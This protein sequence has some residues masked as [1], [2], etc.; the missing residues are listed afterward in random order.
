MTM[1]EFGRR[2]NAGSRKSPSRV[3]A[4]R[5][6]STCG[7]TG[8]AGI[9]R[10][11]RSVL[12]GIGA[13]GLIALAAALIMTTAAAADVLVGKNGARWEGTVTEEDGR[14][15][16][17][18][19]SGGRMVF[20]KDTIAEV[21]VSDDLTEEYEQLRSQADIADDG[22]V[23]ELANIAIEGGLGV[24]YAELLEEAFAV[25]YD[26]I[27][28]DPDALRSL[29]AW[30]AGY[31]LDDRSE[32]CTAEANDMEFR[33][34]LAAV[35]TDAALLEELAVWCADNDQQ[36]RA[37]ECYAQAYELRHEQALGDAGQLAELAEWCAEHDLPEQATQ[38]YLESY[39]ARLGESQDDAAAMVAL[40][41][42]CSARGMTAE[43]ASAEAEAI[44]LA[45][46]DADIRRDLGYTWDE[47]DRE[48]YKVPWEITGALTSDSVVTKEYII[49]TMLGQGGDAYLY[50][51][52][53]FRK[54]IPVKE[55][56]KF[57]VTDN[58]G[59]VR[60]ELFGWDEGKEATLIFEA[61]GEGWS[62]DDELYLN[63]GQHS[64]QIDIS[65]R[66]DIDVD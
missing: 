11:A 22:Q 12:L 15:V 2:L 8:Q 31:G 25:R 10:R 65:G 48:W 60:G 53:A 6:P 63:D 35:S 54:E 49:T 46:D 24:E 9:E 27:R 38:C 42:W 57:Y 43:A 58:A 34:R 14:Y 61:S 33:V 16:L 7:R 44:R 45:P 28:E 29:A 41:Q 30:C 51:G 39:Q 17:V 52:V 56:K 66:L 5:M 32:Q 4:G 50:L 19:I 64:L 37:V 13:V 23:R 59:I 1:R 47:D 36:E 18:T 3:P 21:I 62:E 40:S 55:L 20:P 26:P